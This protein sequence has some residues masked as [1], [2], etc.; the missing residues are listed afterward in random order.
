MKFVISISIFFLVP[1]LFCQTSSDALK[2][3]QK[4]IE[5]KI[6]NTKNLLNTVKNNA[7]ASLNE[8][9]IVD[10]Q[11]KNR[12]A[13]VAVYDNQVQA[14]E[15]KMLEKSNEI[16]T[17]KKKSIKLKSQYRAMLLYAYK[18]RNNSDK[19]MYIL[20]ASSYHEAIKRNKYIKKIAS[21]QKRQVAIIKQHQQLISQEIKNVAIEKSQKLVSLEQKKQEKASIELDKNLLA[22]NLNKLKNEEQKLNAQL[23]IEE[24]KKQELKQKISNAIKV[25]ISIA[26]NKRKKK[27]EQVAKEKATKKE[28]LVVKE[29]PNNEIKP[30][31]VKTPTN[32]IV[33]EKVTPMPK[34]EKEIIYVESDE[35]I[36]LGT[37]FATNKGK[38]PWPVSSG[39]ITEKYGRNAHPT[40]SGVFTNN[41]GIDISCPIGQSVRAIFEGEVTSVFTITGAGKVVI[42]THGNYKTVYSNLQSTDVKIGSKVQ[43]KQKIGT[44]LSEGNISICHFEIQLVANGAI[45]SLNPSLWISK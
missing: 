41:N 6:S 32:V 23:I 3:E 33:P 24:K 11:I 15:I 4:K 34:V 16:N 22:T 38:L 10:N 44:L 43:T 13:L 29:K 7:N 30:T 40:L 39:S 45:Q 35:N 17:L 36:A 42:V 20:S 27:A 14:A 2:K 8:L 25:E 12:E 31:K 19:I 1:S 18:H 37:S 5:K 26:E 9:R 28:K 21:A